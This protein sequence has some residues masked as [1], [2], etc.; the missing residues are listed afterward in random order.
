M[1]HITE[2]RVLETSTTT[3]TGALTLAGA[4]TG[5]RA[6]GS[7][8]TSPSDTCWYSL[9]AVDSN[10]NATGDYEEGL[11]TYSASNT[12]T[13]TTVLR[14]SNANAAV[15]LSAGTKYVAIGALAQR[16]VQLDN[17][18]VAM[19]PEV[20]AA[21]ASTPSAGYMGFFAKKIGG[22]LM[23]AFVGSSGLASVLQ[24]HTAR[25][26]WMQWI[27]AGTGTTIQA[28]GA[29]ALTATG[30][31]TAATYAV[32]YLHTRGRRLDYLV[33]T[34]A[35]TAVAGFRIATNAFRGQEGYHMIF[36]VSPATGGTVG[37]RRFFCGMT[38][39]TA[40]PTDV[41]PSTLTNIL[42]FG[43][44]SADTNW[45]MMVNDGA[46]SATKT[47]T[48]IARPSTDR[49][50]I[51]TISI[52]VPPGGGEA[53]LQF[54]DEGNPG[55]SSYYNV[56]TT[57]IPSATQTMGPRGYHSVGGTSS[58]VGITLFSGYMETDN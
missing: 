36:R 32:T 50:S 12:L 17:S 3:G 44:D 6:F 35:T 8:M 23:P 40:A 52:F 58:V 31:A 39:S 48:G 38:G 11:G 53:R 54:I 15:N 42:G 33:T 27:P 56:A 10:G 30:T 46:G 5:F 9:W 34:A 47:D 57:D 16:V 2:D 20:A 7:V 37:T 29:A 21:G 4:V 25:N 14:S 19:L 13:R 24:P 22:R 49:P 45:Q 41:N 28:T 26:G 18:L 43:Y 55:S 51:Y 1:A